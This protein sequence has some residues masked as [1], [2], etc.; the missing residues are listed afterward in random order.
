MSTRRLQQLIGFFFVAL[1]C[2]SMV[3]VYVNIT[4]LHKSLDFEVQRDYRN[5]A[6]GPT[7]WSRMEARLWRL[8]NVKDEEAYEE[9][10]DAV[11]VLYTRINLLRGYDLDRYNE[12]VISNRQFTLATK[13]EVFAKYNSIVQTINGLVVSLDDYADKIGAPYD[14]PRG[15][16]ESRHLFQGIEVDLSRYTL[17]TLSV[18]I[19]TVDI[20]YTT[21]GIL[22]VIASIVMAVLCLLLIFSVRQ[23]ALLSQAKIAAENATQIKSEF[24]ANMSH[25]I[26]TPLN[27]VIGLA[28]LTK[29]LP[30]A[31]EVKVNI[32][33]I[34]GSAQI[35]L[36]LIN[37]VL[38]FSKIEA[39]KII[40]EQASFDLRDLYKNIDV[41]GTSLLVQKEA[42]KWQSSHE[43]LMQHDV[44]GDRVRIEQIL[45]NIVSNASKFTD[46]GYIDFS[47]K[48][49]KMSE[50]DRIE[51]DITIR[52]TGIGMSQDQLAHVFQPFNQADH[53]T[54]R[55]YGGTGLGLTITQS[56]LQGMDGEMDIY[57]T[58]NQ[59]TC[60]HL[61]IP[62]KCDH[63]PVLKQVGQTQKTL[64]SRI[65]LV[66]DNVINQ[67][68]A[69]SILERKGH[70]VEQ[71]FNGQEALDFMAKKGP[72]AFD[73]ILMDIQMPVMDGHEATRKLIAL[74]GEGL[75]PVIA[76]TAHAI[77]EERQ[78]CYDNGM[79]HFLT[80]PFDPEEILR[81]VAQYG[82]Q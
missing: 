31:P 53:S 42:V 78:I 11:Q 59:G 4:D 65:L 26:R 75:A 72:E 6:R 40:F 67:K 69:R 7:L 82:K 23:K 9:A 81:V 2:G 79:V 76:V 55:K 39:N 47:V 24:L 29:K 15:L 25:E 38:D 74:Y 80:K 58:P 50:Q 49:E 14:V 22:I 57:S 17:E 33:Q 48:T 64:S 61:K 60:I 21:I 20:F 63:E 71:A 51:L 46:K 43:G 45:M 19:E 1:V 56:L 52:D 34:H 44:I 28:H 32:A 30:M 66:E 8:A 62:L 73:L 5:F 18:H 13:E 70:F 35:L 36:S 10:Y 68:V 27:A 16:H 41:L 77:E 3:F 37:D 54:T 12:F